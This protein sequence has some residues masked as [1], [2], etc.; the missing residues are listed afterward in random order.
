[1]EFMI[2]SAN[3]QHVAIAQRLALLKQKERELRIFFSQSHASLGETQEIETKLVALATEIAQLE[4]AI[5]PDVTAK[6]PPKPAL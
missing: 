1:M 3:P 6:K 2:G 4:A 5:S